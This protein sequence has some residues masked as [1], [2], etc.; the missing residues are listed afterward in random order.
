MC[1]K[2]ALA[3]FLGLILSVPA[4]AQNQSV[5][6]NNY[7]GA[8]NVAIPLYN[9]TSGSLSLPVT[10]V[11]QSNGVK[12]KD[13]NSDLGMHWQLIAGGEVSRS[14]RGLP[15]D[16]KQDNAFTPNTRLGWLYN[17]NGTKI[18]SFTIANDNSTAICTDETA[19]NNYINTNFADLSD[20][21]PDVFSVNAPG[22]AFQF[23]FDNSHNIQIVP[24]QDLKVTYETYLYG[25]IKSFKVT[26]D[27]GVTYT[28]ASEQQETRKV[29]N[30][31]TVSYFQQ[32][33]NQYLNGITFNRCWKLTDMSDASG[34]AIH[35]SYT[36]CL[37]KKIYN[38]P[39]SVVLPGNSVATP[40]YN[41]NISYTPKLLGQIFVQNQ[42]G[43]FSTAVAFETTVQHQQNNVYD[44]IS[45]MGR[46]TSFVYDGALPGFDRVFLKSITI[47][48]AGAKKQYGFSYNGF[49]YRVGTTP[50]ILN[51][52]DSTSKEIDYWGYYNASAA[53]SLVPQVYINPSNPAM[54]RY[55]NNAPG[56]AS[57]S[58]PYSV[59]GTNR[60]ANLTAAINGSLSKLYSNLGDTTYVEYE[61]NNY[62]DNTAGAV[63]SGGGIRVK[64]TTAFDGFDTANN[65]VTNYN[66]LDPATGLSSGRPVNMPAYAFTT[67]YTGSGTTAAL[68]ANSTIRSES[69]LSQEDESIIYKNVAISRAGS[70]SIRYEYTVPGTYWEASALPDW[71]PTVVN[72]GRIGCGT[73]TFATSQTNNYPYAPNPNFDF[74]RGLLKKMSTYNETGQQTSEDTY[75]YQRSFA[76]PVM[77]TGLKFDYNTSSA[78]NYT[79]YSAITGTSELL[80]QQTRKVFDLPS[81]T[82]FQTSSTKYNY[83]SA[84][85]KLLTSTELTNSDGSVVKSF[86]KYAKDYATTLGSD[87]MTNSLYRLKLQGI[88]IPVEQY[89]QIQ[90]GSTT[91]T[92]GAGLTLYKNFYRFFNRDLPAQSLQIVSASGLTDFQPSGIVANAFTRDSRYKV[93]ANYLTYD[94]VGQLQTADDNHHNSAT[95]L[96]DNI[97][98]QPFIMIKNAASS[99]FAFDD[100]DSAY[101]VPGFTYSD[102]SKTLKT[103]SDRNG[104][105]ARTIKPAEVIT[106]TGIVKSGFSSNYIF[107]AWANTIAAGT[108][109]IQLTD[110]THT[111]NGTLTVPN[112]SGKW[113]YQETK[114]AISTLNSGFNAS[115]TP[116]ADMLVDDILFYP[117]NSPV[118]TTAYDRESYSKLSETNG[119]GISTYYSYDQF[120]R[121]KFIYDQD[122]NILQK[123]TYADVQDY[124]GYN[125]D[126]IVSLPGTDTLNYGSKISFLNGDQTNL[127]GTKWAWNFGDGSPVIGS[128]SAG[129]FH[130]YNRVGNFTATLTKTS[131]VAG[132]VTSTKTFYVSNH[133]NL[134]V[135][136]SILNRPGANITQVAYS[137]VWGSDSQFAANINLGDM[138]AKQGVYDITV[139]ASGTL[140]NA[141]T[142]NGFKCVYLTD[143]TQ[144]IDCVNFHAGNAV[145]NF[146]GVDLNGRTSLKVSFSTDDCSVVMPIGG[147]QL[148]TPPPAEDH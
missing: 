121:P 31:G 5:S 45:G 128:S 136:F 55:R 77:V 43:V 148:V 131:P 82:T 33:Y 41:I 109:S 20:T 26:N 114:I 89:Q 100:F 64:K 29:T 145:Y 78:R 50:A 83:A 106:K 17:T 52:P 72:S 140:Y 97:S 23:V 1:I 102:T 129:V 12:V 67:P 92:T 134:N 110:G 9:A 51:L 22:L 37:T 61:L 111:S 98:G 32:K 16:V 14:V 7:T 84:A 96:S 28:F 135:P 99:E 44:D 21:E 123:K 11:Y 2:P 93:K 47:E 87:S 40:Q 25:R 120:G 80:M 13:F 42:D 107:S 54:E 95:T 90:R 4:M 132:T 127:E 91:V 105:Y 115:I 116:S 138:V 38:D 147:S 57:A 58:F 74:E 130:A 119:N 143:G 56:S 18:N 85:H 76:S 142:G 94:N 73:G 103:L 144:V 62:Y 118:L 46:K 35:I 8:A 65:M 63:V 19:D 101:P 53:T 108:I 75:T 3:A 49:T 141:S 15:D 68:W 71:A 139:N 66:Y 146:Y 10:A 104:Q 125:A 117:E 122:K 112:T 79:K 133:S 126:M 39:I 86:S 70:G 27:K 113:A 69:D 124:D 48:G 6:V 24:Y 36:D 137:G 88:N 60:T 34:G 81:L 30:A 59:S